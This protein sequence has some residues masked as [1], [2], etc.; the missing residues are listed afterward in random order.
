MGDGIWS[1]ISAA[2]GMEKSILLVLAV[3]SVALWS[4]VFLKIPELR[5]AKRNSARFL[6]L[7]HESDSFAHLKE[8]DTPESEC[9]QLRIF[10]AALGALEGK[11]VA[12][13][14][15]AAKRTPANFAIHP[16]NPTE[17]IM[18]LNMQ[19][20]AAAY[21][22]HMQRGISFLATV[23]STTP[24]VGLFGTV[25]GI[26]TTFQDLGMTKTPSMQV[27][28]PGISGALVATAAGLAVAIPAVIA[29]N[30]I[31]SEIEELREASNAFIER[32]MAVIRANLQMLKNAATPV[33]RPASSPQAAAPAARAAR[34]APPQ[35]RK[36]VPAEPDDEDE[37]EDGD[38]D[39][40]EE[41]AGNR[42]PLAPAQKKGGPN[43]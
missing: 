5:R 12:A 6:E 9:V 22:L 14:S 2:G 26:M 42:A 4:I 21:F 18:L 31:N 1:M 13:P 41:L 8:L 19:H 20:T 37:A 38:E 16:S 15:G 30:T 40:E 17:E 3:C 7:F 32:M 29:C 27:V 25:V 34:P 43:A 35:A 23:G 28:A 39:D 10:K 36:P 24:F 33:A 11:R